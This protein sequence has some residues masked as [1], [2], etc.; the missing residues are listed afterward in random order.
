MNS[1]VFANQVFFAELLE[2]I[3]NGHEVKIRAKGRSMTPLIRDGKDA[4]VLKALEDQSIRIGSIVL[5]LFEGRYVVHRI[6]QISG[7]SIRLRGDGNP[8][9]VEDMS[10]SDI[11][12]ELVAF[13]RNGKLYDAH[14]LRWKVY[15]YLW[16][17]NAFLRRALL[18]IYRRI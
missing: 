14:S 6:T 15:Q 8:Y 3:R 12:A 2:Q 16:P 10:R 4:L 17:S 5:G 7:D 1:K 18:Y 11:L 13:E 9:Q